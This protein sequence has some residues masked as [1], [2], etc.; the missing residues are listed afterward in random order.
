MGLSI[1][2]FGQATRRGRVAATVPPGAVAQ[3]APD[4]RDG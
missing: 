2:A 1:D 3:P 4:I